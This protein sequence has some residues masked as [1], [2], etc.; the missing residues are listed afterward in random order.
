M[1]RESKDPAKIKENEAKEKAE[2]QADEN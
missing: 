2:K 1:L